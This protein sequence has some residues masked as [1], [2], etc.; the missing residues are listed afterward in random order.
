MILIT[1]S[2]LHPKCIAPNFLQ[3]ENG[4]TINTTTVNNQIELFEGIS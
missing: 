3:I 1:T 2:M 4:T